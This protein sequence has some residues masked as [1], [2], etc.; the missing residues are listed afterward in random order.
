MVKRVCVVTGS[1]AEY[2]LLKGLLEEIRNEPCLELQLIVT[3]MHLSHE[4]GLTV[5][6]IEN[7]GFQIQRRVEMLLSS[8]SSVGVTKSIGLGVIGFADA[9]ADLRPNL[10][11]VLG[12]RFEILAAAIAALIA[13]VPVAHLHGGESTIGALDDAIR[14]SITKMASLHF[15][16]AEEYRRR[17]IQLG[18]HPERVFLVGGLG[19]DGIQRQKL[20]SKTE[21]ESELGVKF[22]SKMLLVTYHPETL[23]QDSLHGLESMLTALSDLE[24]VTLIFT[25]P[26]ADNGGRQ[27]MHRIE[28]YCATREDAFAF[29]SLGQSRYLSCLLH[30]DGIVGNSSSGLLEAPSLKKG[31]INIGD[32]QK[33]RLRASSIIDVPASAGAIMEA[34]KILFSTSFQDDLRHAEN[35]YGDGGASRRIAKLIATQELDGLQRKVFYDLSTV[36]ADDSRL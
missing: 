29:K 2:G 1:R 3:G 30:C 20:L 14:H 4:F 28:K 9:I 24:D 21:L 36:L 33:G 16:A 26:N 18:E 13:K 31:T 5:K 27:I 11:V 35:P 17:V 12:D 22:R 19:V 25:L 34:V 23:E 32:R 15:V 10:I 6:E 8:D 7:D